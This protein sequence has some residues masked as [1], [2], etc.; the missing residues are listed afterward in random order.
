MWGVRCQ[1]DAVLVAMLEAIVSPPRL[2]RYRDAGKSDLETITNYLWNIQLAEAL[3]PSIA[4]LEVCLRNTVHQTLTAHSGTEYWFRG[5]LHPA[6]WPA[7]EKEIAALSGVSTM[8][9]I[10]LPQVLPP[11]GKIIAQLTFGFWPHIFSR[12]YRKLWWTPQ[13]QLISD[14]LAHHPNLTAATRSDL[15]RRLMYFNVLRNR[16]MHHEA[17][18]DG[19]AIP[20][21]PVQTIDVLHGEILET[22]RWIN[23]DAERLLN[24]LDRFTSVFDPTGPHGRLGIE[25]A[26]RNEYGIT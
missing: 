12:H 23:P 1:V 22:I 17:I 24:C 5:L 15:H 19:V 9:P 21:H 20:N 2:K 4:M 18:F 25:S 3:L 14:V 11:A 16:A 6:R 13:S 26:I 7:V 10:A 8:P